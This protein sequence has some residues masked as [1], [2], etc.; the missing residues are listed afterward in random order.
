M[1][2]WEEQWVEV[3]ETESLQMPV[4]AQNHC[5]VGTASEKNNSTRQQL[6]HSTLSLDLL[7]IKFRVCIRKVSKFSDWV[8]KIVQGT[9][10]YLLP[11]FAFVNVY[12]L[13]PLVI[14]LYMYFFFFPSQNNLRLSQKNHVP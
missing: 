12:N 3:S 1:R 7:F 2:D 4:S 10:M 11:R 13:L 9:G 6:L 5:V 8:L 14:S